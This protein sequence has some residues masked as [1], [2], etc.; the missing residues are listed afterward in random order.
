GAAGLL[1]EYDANLSLVANE[2]N[3]N[4]KSTELKGVYGS[5]ITLNGQTLDNI[6]GAE[7]R[8]HSQGNLWIYAPNMT[9]W[10][11]NIP[12]IEIA[13]DAPFSYSYLPALTLR[14]DGAQWDV[15]VA[16]TVTC[17]GINAYNNNLLSG[18]FYITLI[19]YN[20]NLG[21]AANS[22]DVV[23]TTGQGIT[24]NGVHLSEI[25]GASVNYAHGTTHMQIRIPKNYQ[26]ALT[27]NI[28]LEVVSGTTFESQVLDGAKFALTS[29]SWKRVYDVTLSRVRWNDEDAGGN[30]DGKKGV[31]LQ[32]DANLSTVASEINGGIRDTNLAS[33][34]GEYIYLGGQKLS[35]LSGALV[36]YHSQDNLFI[37]ADNM[38]AYRTFTIEEGTPILNALLPEI[39]LYYNGNSKWTTTNRAISPVTY[40]NIQWNNIG[41]QTFEGKNGVLLNFSENLSLNINEI[42]GGLASANL[43]NLYGSYI[44]LNGQ[45]LDN[46]ANA[47]LA[48]FNTTFV[49]I[50]APGMT[51]WENHVP[52]IE[53]AANA[54]FLDVYLPA[55]TIYFYS[56]EW[57]VT[58]PKVITINYTAG[59]FSRVKFIETS[60]TVDSDYLSDI[61]SDAYENITVLCWS[62]G[63]M[64]YFYG[65]TPSVN[66]ATTVNITE[67]LN[68]YTRGGASIRLS[69][70][71]VTGLRFESRINTADYNAIIENYDDV[72]FGT[73]IAPKA[74]LDA[75][76]VANAGTTFKDYFGQA[77][78]SGTSTKYVKVVN[79]GIY[80]SATYE[81]DGYV[82]YFGSLANIYEVNYY[83]KFVGVGYVKFT[84]GV[85]TYVIFGA[86]TLKNTTRTV[87]DVAKNAYNDTSEDY[88][89]S[90]LNSIKV[91]IDAVADLTYK[92][93]NLSVNEVITEREYSSPYQASLNS[94]Y[95]YIARFG[96]EELPRTILINGKKISP[97][98]FGSSINAGSIVMHIAVDNM[99]TLFT[100]GVVYGVGEPDSNLW[101][102]NN[103]V[104]TASMLSDIT[105]AL[106]ATA[107]RVWLQNTANISSSNDVSLVPAQ[108]TE[109]K[110][111]IDGLAD[112]GVE[113]IY[114]IGVHF[115]SATYANYYVD[116]VGWETGY[117]YYTN[118]NGTTFYRDYSCVPD[119]STEA[120]AYAEWLKVQADY[121]SL[122]TAQI[123]AWKE[124]SPA[125]NN[126]R[127]YFEGIN[128]PEG[129][130]VIHKRGS[131]N[132]STGE[133]TYNYFN[134]ATL[135][136]ILTDVSYYMTLAVNANLDGVGYVTTPA[137]MY[138]TSGS[139]QVPVSGVSSDGLLGAMATAIKDNVAPTAISGITPANTNDPEAYFTVLNWHPY[140]SWLK[141]EH[142]ELYYAEVTS[143]S[144]LFSGT[145]WNAEVNSDYA[146]DW[147]NWNNG[148]YSIFVDQFT[149]F[150][151]K[152]VFTEIGMIDFGT[153]VS[154][155]THYTAVGVSESLA[156]TVFSNLLSAMDG[157]TFSNNCTVIA[158]RLCDVESILKADQA[159]QGYLDIYV[160]GEG[161]LGLIEEDGTIKAIMRE[162]Y[163]IINGNR[164]TTA[165]QTVVSGYYD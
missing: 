163:Y 157:L 101:A 139:G 122:L 62:I 152:V 75:Y 106:G 74:L 46:I 68:F 17:S 58:A 22:T 59:D 98:N 148:M 82:K 119:P 102:N 39:N 38:A 111:L 162:Y 135:A 160:Y 72:E 42:N 54:P 120:A 112:N 70:D 108:M 45:T 137:L 32:F 153:H 63:G 145:T 87:Y 107:F 131:Y 53:I 92:L 3:G 158:F 48:Y 125:W 51:A 2:I 90:Q 81:S 103:T 97:S 147:V 29:G 146:T 60:I 100:D 93:G 144:S 113:E 8:Y 61:L 10:E 138:L 104:A 142:N 44:T 31:L 57:K 143:S 99:A 83:T 154:F 27:G 159:T 76:L 12:T 56:G 69:G 133:Y 66:V 136:K 94:G 118:H 151:P 19:D 130:V 43:K 35:T 73:Y 89:V 149:G 13:E 14:F 67:V 114:L 9:T 47:E 85:N 141:S 105:G 40:S 65:D 21:D 123:A 161:N 15:Y 49:W 117:S 115:P 150:A 26:D 24:L 156:A 7:L 164:N 34:V 124:N 78:G 88:S 155:S 140:L 121:Y 30:Y 37:Y 132:F 77:Q 11:N 50:Y 71:G 5:Y 25:S 28:I 109:L 33:T 79:V 110:N 84:K 86:T 55:V 134:T 126:I 16:P 1:L 6:A 96:S 4:I 23:S 80:N 18:S 95:Y 36:S 165:L 128:E 116:G 41:Y 52:T 127:F 64:D 129:Q 20:T 91:Y